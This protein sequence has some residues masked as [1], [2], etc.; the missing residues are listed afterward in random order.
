MALSKSFR[1]EIVCS[2]RRLQPLIES[3]ILWETPNNLF[4]ESVYIEVLIRLNDLL[5]KSRILGKRISFTDDIKVGGEVSDI[6]DLVRVFRDCVC[7]M[8]TDK[9]KHGEK[10]YAFIELRGKKKYEHDE[11]IECLY[12][13]EIAFIMG[14]NILYLQRHVE[15]SFFELK[16]LYAYFLG[17]VLFNFSIN[18]ELLTPIVLHKD[19]NE[20][21]TE[22]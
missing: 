22:D 7:H 4:R 21:I 19:F 3:R 1:F 6:T 5:Q 8:D 15:R 18:A 12:E 2:L 11:T 14:G 13:N 10:S 20:E 17:Q 9:R 16:Q